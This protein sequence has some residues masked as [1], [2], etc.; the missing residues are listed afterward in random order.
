MKYFS[1]VTLSP[2]AVGRDLVSIMG[3]QAYG[4]HAFVWSLFADHAERRRDFLY[5]VE[6]RQSKP[7]VYILSGRSPETPRGGFLIERRDWSPRLQTGDLLRFNLRV[8]PVVSRRDGDGR[9]HRFDIIMDR[10]IRENAEGKART[11]LFRIVQEEGHRWLDERSSRS[12]FRLHAVVA[13]GYTQQRFHKSKGGPLV[14]FATID[15]EGLLEVTDTDR[16]LDSVHGG[17]GPA[18][19]FGCG[20]MLLRRG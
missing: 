19:G 11:P 3:N 9:Q 10:R 15:M 6:V 1:K 8:N 4:M 5:R 17:F 20:L 18:K 14:S 16:F 7:V 13:D 12:G 2:D